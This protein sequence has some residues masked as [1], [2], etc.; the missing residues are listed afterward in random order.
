MAVQWKYNSGSEDNSAKDNRKTEIWYGSEIEIDAFIAGLSIGTNYFG[1]GTL[2]NYRKHPAEGPIYEVELIYATT[3][4]D[5]GNSI[6][7]DSATGPNS[8]RLSCRTISMPLESKRNRNGSLKYRTCWNYYLIGLGENYKIIPGWWSTATDT[9]I[10]SETDRK[11][12]R[13]VKSTAEI[14]TTAEE[15][16]FW[17]IVKNDKTVC[18]PTKPGI[19]SFDLAVYQITETGEHSKKDKA[20]WAATTAINSIVAKPSLGDFGLTALL[21][22][23]WKVDD[24]EVFYN[25][26]KWI[27]TMTHTKSGDA[28]GWDT[29]LYGN[30]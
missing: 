19:E 30:Q 17:R 2:T 4:D 25:G 18:K 26:R 27:A 24:A 8:Q 22:G 28:L 7:A 14:P 21:G 23:N 29:D 5:Y 12:Y 3:R 16:N 1:K 13:W 11:N 9:L 6:D 15:G 20:G 10:E